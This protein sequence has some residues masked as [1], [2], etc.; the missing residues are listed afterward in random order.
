MEENS[1]LQRLGKCKRLSRNECVSVERV[2]YIRMGRISME[3]VI[4]IR[5]EVIFDSRKKNPFLQF[6]FRHWTLNI[7]MRENQ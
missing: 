2:K 4:I 5:L 1:V 6:I 7:S 3:Y